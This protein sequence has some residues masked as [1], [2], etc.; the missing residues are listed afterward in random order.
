M[1]TA[2]AAIDWSGQFYNACTLIQLRSNQKK[3]LKNYINYPEKGVYLHCFVIVCIY[4]S[5]V[6]AASVDAA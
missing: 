6:A 1:Q 4:T 3:I 5:I 2:A